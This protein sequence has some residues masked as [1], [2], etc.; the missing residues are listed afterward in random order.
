MKDIENIMRAYAGSHPEYAF[1]NAEFYAITLDSCVSRGYQLYSPAI[2]EL[3]VPSPANL[4]KIRS[5]V[6]GY[7]EE[8][9]AELN[10]KRIVSAMF[11]VCKITLPCLV[12]DAALD[13]E[14]DNEVCDELC[15]DMTTVCADDG[16]TYLVNLDT[17][18][19]VFYKA[20]ADALTPF[21]L[22]EDVSEITETLDRLP[23]LLAQ[24]PE[25]NIFID[26]TY[27]LD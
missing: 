22:N 19:N 3:Y 7:A 21:G 17:F 6:L 26:A 5:L 14:K 11:D 2:D 25:H 12:R 13:A 20:P 23:A 27:Q 9:R 1:E 8:V 24:F 15:R 10:G 4:E 18:Y 16:K